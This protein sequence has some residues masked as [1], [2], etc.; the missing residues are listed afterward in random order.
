MTP[1]PRRRTIGHE[2][3]NRKTHVYL[4]ATEHG[5][6]ETLAG[7]WGCTVS[8]LI[9]ALC[10]IGVECIEH[11]GAGPDDRGVCTVPGNPAHLWESSDP[12]PDPTVLNPFGLGHDHG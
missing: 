1:S 10:E 11:H 6:L 12:E 8:T 5:A 3:R 2:P 4:T 9:R 7:R